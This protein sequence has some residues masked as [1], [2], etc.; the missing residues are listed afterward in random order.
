M[1]P[2]AGNNIKIVVQVDTLPAEVDRLRAA[3]EAV[4]RRF[5]AASATA[6]ITV[7]DDAQMRKV[8]YEFLRKRSTTD[9]V[10]FDLT[11]EFDKRRV[12]EVVVN[13][14]RADRQARKRGHS[15]EAELALYIVHGLLHNLGF[16]DGDAEQAEKMHRT[17]DAILKK[18][19]YGSIYFGHRKE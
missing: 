14:D 9:V 15:T 4:L 5:R 2:R 12:F 11:D 1:T 16:D 10:S 3:A 7:V 18:L 19:G 17:E 6:T 8:H 13:A